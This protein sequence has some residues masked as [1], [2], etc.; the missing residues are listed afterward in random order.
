[1]NGQV[2]S[3][4]TASG[5]YT[6]ASREISQDPLS[7]NLDGHQR[8]TPAGT[9]RSHAGSHRGGRPPGDPDK[10][11]QPSGTR[12]RSRTDPNK[13]GGPYGN[14]RICECSAVSSR[15]REVQELRLGSDLGMVPEW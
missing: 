2:I 1:V 13:C 6:I 3:A 12:P 14:L 4:A 5:G 10:H 11:E 9:A 8:L 15:R 7:G